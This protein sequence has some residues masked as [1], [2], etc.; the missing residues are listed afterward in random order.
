MLVTGWHYWASKENGRKSDSQWRK[1]VNVRFGKNP[2]SCPNGGCGTRGRRTTDTGQIVCR[3]PAAQ[4]P[5]PGDGPLLGL[6]RERDRWITRLST[7]P[8]HQL[9]RESCSPSYPVR[10]LTVSLYLET[11]PGRKTGS[12]TPLAPQLRATWTTWFPFQRFLQDLS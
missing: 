8:S 11:R 3:A 10:I 2:C 4:T 1:F 12:W 9:L 6:L 7:G 5:R